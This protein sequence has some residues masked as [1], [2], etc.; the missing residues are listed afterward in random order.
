MDLLYSAVLALNNAQFSIFKSRK[1]VNHAHCHANHAIIQSV[2]VLLA[3]L[4]IFSFKISV[5]KTALIIYSNLM[6]NVW[7]VKHLV[8][9]A[10]ISQQSA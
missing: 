5:I 3:F 9:L 8:S 2:T 1:S 10:K 7:S 4:N 6:G